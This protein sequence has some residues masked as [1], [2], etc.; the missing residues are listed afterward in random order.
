[1]PESFIPFEPDFVQHA[2][3]VSPD[4]VLSF[5]L[6]PTQVASYGTALAVARLLGGRVV[7]APFLWWKTSYP[8]LHVQVPGGA[9]LNAGLMADLFRKYGVQW[10]SYAWEVIRRD[11]AGS[12]PIFSDPSAAIRPVYGPPS[13]MPDLSATAPP[14]AVSPPRATVPP[15]ASPPAAAGGAGAGPAAAPPQEFRPQLYGVIGGAGGGSAGGPIGIVIGAIIGGLFSIFGGGG[16]SKEVRRALEGLRGA[17]ADT[18]ENSMRFTWKTA[19]GLGWLIR[20]I[21]TLW[22]RILHPLLDTVNN[23]ARKLSRLIDRV[24]KPYFELMRKIREH[25]LLI[26]EKYVAPVLIAIETLRKMLAIFR[27]AGFKWAEKLDAELARLESRISQPFLWLLAKTNEIA[28]WMNVLL[29]VQLILQQPILVNSLHAYSKIW[30]RMFWNAHLA[31]P[32]SGGSGGA[33]TGRPPTTA[34]EAAAGLR[35]YAKYGAGPYAAAA[36]D[37][38]AKV[39]AQLKG[40]L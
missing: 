13:E 22:V 25:I 23:I 38:A 18:A 2:E 11:A 3:V 7:E 10:T 33:V 26:Y 36:A 14:Q 9:V 15:P 1:M 34:R 16:V 39:K 37:I 40:T 27:L 29:N 8:I 19:F 35:L 32:G 28:G 4:G 12:A 20:S 31:P 17:I 30:A 6:N 21:Q 5:E 24:L